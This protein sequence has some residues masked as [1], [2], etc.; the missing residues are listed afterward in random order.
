MSKLPIFMLLFILFN[1]ISCSDYVASKREGL[2]P[3]HDQNEKQA[4]EEPVD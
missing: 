3:F 4:Q 2:K 1:L